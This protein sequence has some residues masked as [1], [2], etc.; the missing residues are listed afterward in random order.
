[1][2]HAFIGIDHVQIAAPPGAEARARAFF[3]DLLGMTEVLKPVSLRGRGGV[4]F[5]CGAQQLH[6][7][8]E[9][10]FSPAKKAHPAIRVQNLAELRLRLQQANIEMIEDDS[11]PGAERFYVNDPFGNRLEFLELQ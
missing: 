3:A 7:G 5:Q 2:P 1:L 9:A 4:W 11:L 6:V 8:I 10:N